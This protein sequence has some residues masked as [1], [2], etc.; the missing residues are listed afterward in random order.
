VVG[1]AIWVGL[2]ATACDTQ[3][4]PFLEDFA[5]PRHIVNGFL[6]ASRDTQYVRVQ[7]LRRTTEAAPAIPDEFVVTS[8]VEGLP[9]TTW[10]DSIV[11]LDDGNSGHLYSAVFRPVAGDT[12]TIRV[13]DSG[14]T[15]ELETTVPEE[16]AL[17]VDPPS[18]G[19]AITQTIMLVG[20]NE[21]PPELR[22]VYDVTD[23][24]SMERREFSYPYNGVGRNLSVGWGFD[25]F[26]SSDRN[27]IDIDLGATANDSLL[28]LNSVRVS[29]ELLSSDWA[30]AQGSRVPSFFGAVGVYEIPWL[31]DDSTRLALRFMP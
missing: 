16:P 3:V 24:V 5:P 10:R 8:V 13:S 31:L 2:F 7:R 6:D 14:D 12:Y 25:V 23:P 27:R 1:A 18:T 4:E 30:I 19:S 22:V 15:T 17:V 9:E 21:R 11:A 28:M 20:R 29:F 26:L